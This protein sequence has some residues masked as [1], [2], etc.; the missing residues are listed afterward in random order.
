MRT[1]RVPQALHGQL[2]LFCDEMLSRGWTQ[3]SKS[4]WCCLVLILKKPSGGWQLLVDLCDVNAR[5]KPISYFIPSMFAKYQNIKYMLPESRM[6]PAQSRQRIATKTSIVQHH[7]EIS[8]IKLFP[9]GLISS[10]HYF[11]HDLACIMRNNGILYD[12]LAIDAQ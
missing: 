3:P 6:L 9:M 2:K 10:T 5:T 11:Q 12:K 7:T 8:S 1:Y 4:K